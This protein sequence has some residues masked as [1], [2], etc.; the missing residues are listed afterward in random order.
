MQIK[1]M[2]RILL[3]AAA[4][5]T[6]SVVDAASVAA[7]VKAVRAEITSNSVD[8]TTKCAYY[9]AWFADLCTK[10]E[11]KAIL[12]RNIAAHRRWMELKPNTVAPNVGLGRTLAAVSRW[13]EAEKELEKALAGNEQYH[14]V[15]ALWDLANCLWR[16]GDKQGAKKLLSELVEGAKEWPSAFGGL[17]R[18]AKY[19][20]TMF[21]DPDAYLD[22]FQLPHNTD[23]KPFPTPQRAE[24]GTGRLSLA[25]VELEVKGLKGEKVKSLEGEDPIVRLLKRKL[26]RFGTEFEK[27]GTKVVLELSENAP[28]DKPQGYSI[29]VIGKREEVIGNGGQGLGVRD[30]ASGNGEAVIRARDRLGLLWGVVSFIQCI[31]RGNSSL[32]RRSLLSRRSAV[33]TQ[34]DGEGGNS[35]PLNPSIRTMRIV[36]WPKC[37]RRGVINYWADD[38]LEYALFNKMNMLNIRMDREYSPSPLDCER[39]R[40]WCAAFREFGIEMYCGSGDIMMKPILPLSSPRTRKLHLKWARFIAS[41][42]GNFAIHLDDSR[43]PMHPLDLEKAGA[44]ANIDAKHFNDIYREVKKEYPDFKMLFCPPFY[45]GPDGGVRYS[46]PR[47][48]YL[49]SLASDLDP[50][51]EVFWT[52]PRVKSMGMSDEK[53]D[54][55]AGLIGRK[56]VI[57]HNSNCIGQHNHIPY[58]ADVSG[59]KASHSTNLFD[60]ISAFLHNMSRYQSACVIGPCMDWCWNPEAH[61]PETAVRRIDE[62]LVGPGVFEILREAMPAVAYFDKYIYGELRSELLTENPDDLDRRVSEAEAAWEKVLAIAKNDGL[63]VSDFDRCGIKWARKLAANCRNP[64]KW[65]KEK[66]DAEMANTAFA[67][68]EVGYDAAKGDVFYPA[69]LLNGAQYVQNIG[70]WGNSGKRNVKYVNVGEEVSGTFDCGADFPP[71]RPFRLVFV[72]SPWNGHETFAEVEVNGRRIWS[73]SA[74]AEKHHFTPLEIEIPV[75]ALQRSNNRFVFRNSAPLQESQR[76]P[77]VHYAV[78]KRQ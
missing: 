52:G 76:K 36:D 71:E 56:P 7:Q 25:K 64:P 15:E 74:F 78:L 19:L 1:I 32:P 42:G 60:H 75:D 14:R 77:M 46:E 20:L 26:G 21:D 38:F 22:V 44:G 24:Y 61:D 50:E 62:M 68:K 41:I 5:A 59:Y 49:K 72:G 57:F 51:I 31:D 65:L 55:Y 47:D 53:T 3:V 70:G 37:L 43:Y 30:Q 69:E 4:A 29:E 40:L 12:D 33:G 2:K 66:Y 58:G 45:W 17:A 35:Q 16:K 73:G 39:Y 10:D 28:V 9:K 8:R 23:C 11:L 13:D 67:E 6:A 18:R 54:W 27:G 63:F 34:A 48:A